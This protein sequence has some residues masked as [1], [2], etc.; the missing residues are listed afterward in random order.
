M[1]MQY[2]KRQSPIAQARIGILTI[3]T[4][5]S[6]NHWGIPCVLTM[7]IPLLP[8]VIH[9]CRQEYG[10]TMTMLLST[11]SNR[12]WHLQMSLQSVMIDSRSLQML[13]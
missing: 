13:E 3:T 9:H 6:G 8:V 10:V 1:D 2:Q 12:M 11:I 7:S 5:S 4:G